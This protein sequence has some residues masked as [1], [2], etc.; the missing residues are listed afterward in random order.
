M[1]SKIGACLMAIL[2]ILPV[3]YSQSSKQN[4]RNDSI[5]TLKLDKKIQSWGRLGGIAVDKLGFIY[6]SNFGERGL[7]DI[8]GE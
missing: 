3:T 2:F 6:M 7:E 1:K 8:A 5:S 4:Y